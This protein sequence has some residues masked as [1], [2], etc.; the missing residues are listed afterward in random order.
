MPSRVMH[1]CHVDTCGCF[2]RELGNLATT[3]V[4][5][6]FKAPALLLRSVKDTWRSQPLW[7][8]QSGWLLNYGGLFNNGWLFNV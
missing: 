6:L 3:C 2:Q 1:T 4:W 8:R 5:C 7:I